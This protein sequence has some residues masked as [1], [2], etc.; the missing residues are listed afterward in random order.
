MTAEPDQVEEA[1]SDPEPEPWREYDTIFNGVQDGRIERVLVV[2]AHP[3]DIVE[4]AGTVGALRR[5]GVSVD[6][7]FVTAGDRRVE[8]TAGGVE[9]APAAFAAREASRLGAQSLRILGHRELEVF[10]SFELRRELVREIRGSRPDVVISWDPTPGLRQHPDHRVVGRMVVD[11]AWPCAA[12]ALIHEDA[13]APHD[14]REAWLL[15]SPSPD[16]FLDAG[17]DR[18]ERYAQIDLRAGPTR[19]PRGIDQERSNT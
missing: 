17:G 10:E 8:R 15:G 14:V 16:L 13:G 12:S 5:R 11:A 4:C 3:A 9:M 19:P 7:V 18:E 1:W 2:L 6:L